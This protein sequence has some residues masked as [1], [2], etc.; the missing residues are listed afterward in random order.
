MNTPPRKV[1]C[2]IYCRKSSEEG[3][4]QAFSSLHAQ[5]ESCLSYV[6][7]QAHE[8]WIALDEAYDDPGFSGGTLERPALRRLI[9]DMEEETIDA[10]ICY[11]IDRLTR[12]LSDFT[13]LIDIFERHKISLVSITEHFNTAT[14]IGR[15]N[16]HMILSFAQYERELAGE[17]IR[18]KFLQ[19]RKRGLWMGGHA[20][21]GFDVRERKLVANETEAALVR[22]VFERFLQVGSATK[23]VQELNAAGHHTKRGKPFDKGVIYKLLKN[24]TYIGEVQHKGTSYPGEHDP[25]IERDTW[26]KVH[27]I[28]AENGHRRASRTRAVTPALL[29]GLII[30]PD[31]KVMAPSHTRRRG[32][33]YRFYRTA[34]SLK[35]CHGACPIRA[36]PAGEVEAAVVN[37]IRTLLRAPE[38]VVRTWC[39]ARVEDEQ[40]DEGEVIEAL[41]RLDP[42]WDQLFPAEQARVLQLLVAR[43]VVKLDGLE[44][45]LR[46]EGLT[47]VIQDLQRHKGAERQAA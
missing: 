20:P 11:R 25:I 13:R 27:A 33:L 21:L 29:K 2:A 36:V 5:R 3:V 4:A 19:S 30:G 18:H 16:L 28:L 44:I 35:L 1:R 22:H 6:R 9:H 42:L 26:D 14:P 47:S 24:H 39:A 34:T 10:V 46:V 45:N 23:L 32:R 17:R 7:S 15:L 41:Q 31:G 8:G 38:I 40:I 43:V 12:S 37:Q